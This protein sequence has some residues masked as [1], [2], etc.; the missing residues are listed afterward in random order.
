MPD[1][2][3]IL[4]QTKLHQ[5]RLPKDLLTRSRLIELLNHEMDRQLIL[6]CAPAGFGKTT[7][8]STWLEH[9]AAA[10]GEKVTSLPS[11]WLSLDEND[12]DLNLYLR[13]IIAALRTIFSEA[14]EDTLALLQARQQPPDE[15]IYTTFSNELDKLPGECILVLDDYHTIQGEEVHNLLAELV[16]HWPRPLHLVLISRIDPPIPLSSFRARGM[17][18]EI[19]TQDLRF[20]PEETAAYLSQRAI[21]PFEPARSAPAG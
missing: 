20:A 12:R 18:S 14:C 15:V 5:P 1:S 17:L 4:L 6:V 2:N 8:V 10:Q 13:Y 3:P 9:K 11:A 7:L 19:R 21:C 16:R